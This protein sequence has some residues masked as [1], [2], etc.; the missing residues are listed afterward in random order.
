MYE[1]VVR[2]SFCAAHNLREY[3]GSCEKL[4]GHDWG[5]EIRVSADKLDRLGMAL[6][7]RKLK[8]KLDQILDRLDHGYLNEIDEF[9][10]VNPTTENI[11]RWVF[12]KLGPQLPAGVRLERV[13]VSESP[14]CSA[15]YI[16]D[17]TEA[18]VAPR[19][20]RRRRDS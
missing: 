14:E 13:S 15:T 11:A 6:D 12:E 9:T 18:R 8:T 20:R 2:R 19:D 10:R 5:V 1:L 16:P 4:H 17:M 7:F 3:R